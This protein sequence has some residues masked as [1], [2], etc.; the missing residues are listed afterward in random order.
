MS[1][2]PK[3]C[4]RRVKNDFLGLKDSFSTLEKPFLR[5]KMIIR[6]IQSPFFRPKKP[7]FSKYP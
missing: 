6:A 2:S 4:P 1:L 5:P 7:L 3:K